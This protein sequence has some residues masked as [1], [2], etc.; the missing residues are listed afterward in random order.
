MC[1]SSVTDLRFNRSSKLDHLLCI[2]RRGCYK[3]L[4]RESL[5]R[6]QVSFLCEWSIIRDKQIPQCFPESWKK[7]YFKLISLYCF[8]VAVQLHGPVWLFATPWTTA[9]QAS[10]TSLSPWV[11][12][13]SC[14][15]LFKYLQHYSPGEERNGTWTRPGSM[16]DTGCLGLVHW[17]DPKGWYEEGGGRGIQDGEHVYTHGRFMMMNGKTNTVL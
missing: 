7:K 3:K 6:Q 5:E 14:I 17:D 8:F 15:A 1:L 11:C 2:D 12:S 10:P 13:N 9:C 4:M 16:H